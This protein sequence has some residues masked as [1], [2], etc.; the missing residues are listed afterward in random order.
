MEVGQDFFTQKKITKKKDQRKEETVPNTTK[1]GMNVSS[2]N[3]DR[4]R[5]T[6]ISRKKSFLSNDPI[7][8]II[9][10]TSFTS[11][12]IQYTFPSMSNLTSPFHTSTSLSSTSS[13]SFATSVPTSS[14]PS[15]VIAAERLGQFTALLLKPLKCLI[16][17]EW[18]VWIFFFQSK[19]STK[20]KT[21]KQSIKLSQDEK[22]ENE[23]MLLTI[24]TMSSTSHWP[25]I[26]PS[27]L[28]LSCSY[29][30]LPS[31]LSTSKVCSTWNSILKRAPSAFLSSS[32]SLRSSS[33][34]LTTSKLNRICRSIPYLAALEYQPL[35]DEQTILDEIKLM[36]QKQKEMLLSIQ[37]QQ[38]D[39]I[40]D[41]DSSLNRSQ[42]LSTT[43]DP[44]TL[45][46]YSIFTFH[47]LRVLFLPSLQPSFSDSECFSLFTHCPLLESFFL[48]IHRNH[49]LI[50]N[51][52]LLK[53]SSSPPSSSTSSYSQ[54][55]R[56]SSIGFSYLSSLK[57]LSSF[58]LIFEHTSDAA[59]LEDDDLT[60]FHL[61]SN[62]FGCVSTILMKS[63]SLKNF[64]LLHFPQLK[65]RFSVV[66]ANVASAHNTPSI[67][68]SASS[69]I[70]SLLSLSVDEHSVVPFL[71]SS[72]SSL[73][74]LFVFPS[75]S[76]APGH[77]IPIQPLSMTVFSSL[78]SFSYCASS[79]V[80]SSSDSYSLTEKELLQ[81][82]P[83][84]INLVGLHLQLSFC[85]INDLKTILSSSLPQRIL[86][87]AFTCT[88]ISTSLSSIDFI[89]FLGHFSKL[90]DLSLGFLGNF[91][92]FT[93]ADFSYLFSHLPNLFAFHLEYGLQTSPSLTFLSTFL[94]E[95]NA[96]SHLI[97][98]DLSFSSSFASIHSTELEKEISLHSDTFQQ[99]HEIYHEYEERYELSEGIMSDH[100]RHL[101]Q[102]VRKGRH[103]K[104][105][106][107]RRKRSNNTAALGTEDWY[108]WLY[109][110]DGVDEEEEDT[111]EFFDEESLSLPLSV[112]LAR[113]DDPNLEYTIAVNQSQPYTSQCVDMWKHLRY[114]GALR[115]GCHLRHYRR[116]STNNIPVTRPI[117]L[118]PKRITTRATVP[119]EDAD[120][121]LEA[122]TV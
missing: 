43:P 94:P 2:V 73:P 81:Q 60:I 115:D 110:G 16:P 120:L 57:H 47:T 33:T 59:M 5:I 42:P 105:M 71:S 38:D 83:S 50:S 121:K 8:D 17:K 12:T 98:F 7:N 29:L 6:S 3:K 102:N 89:H 52:P 90:A 46:L 69:P 23:N 66:D 65:Q 62:C 25:A 119:L 58:S 70:S 45:H 27:L 67:S 9:P 113:F 88:N 64:N 93:S 111:Q 19:P 39:D 18:L 100:Q 37:L 44:R 34:I 15:A 26:S 78:V 95:Q 109:E 72:W 20:K 86:Q 80:V 108:E 103:K 122:I 48:T 32:L 92:A 49:F 76:S 11:S 55:F 116:N 85:D 36:K 14:A 4:K 104:Q 21:T 63:K 53:Q 91:S 35:I 96:P 82:L 61:K 84:L 117:R 99:L 87:L 31:L 75:S 68:S 51:S 28:A 22:E 74:S 40:D 56:L 10:F 24:S 118:L 13:A 101:H 107:E 112:P 114:L 97:Y 79:S 30:S 54:S 41:V 77:Q 106:M 1:T